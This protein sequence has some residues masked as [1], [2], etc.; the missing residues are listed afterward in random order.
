MPTLIHRI[1]R[2]A[3]P[4]RPVVANA[5]ILLWFAARGKN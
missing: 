4:L 3:A 2:L 5:Q 1:T